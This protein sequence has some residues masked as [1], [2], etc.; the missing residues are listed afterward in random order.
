V[1]A[2]SDTMAKCPESTLSSV[3]HTIETNHRA[4]FAPLFGI[5]AE[6]K[7]LTLEAAVLHKKYSVLNYPLCDPSLAYRMT[8]LM[9]LT[10]VRKRRVEV[11]RSYVCGR[12]KDP[13][14]PRHAERTAENSGT[15]GQRA[16]MNRARK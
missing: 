2:T 7:N 11:D 14:C 9:S 3:P 5:R 13:A 4:A 12:H 16:K 6:G 10:A 8:T 1:N 15:F